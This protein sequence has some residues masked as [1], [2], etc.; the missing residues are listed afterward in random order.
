[1]VAELEFG[2]LGPLAVRRHGRAVPIAQG[3]QRAVLAALLLSAG[4]AV[5]TDELSEALWGAEPPLTAR[6]TLQNYVMRLRKALGDAG[7]SR[8]TAEPDGY[9]IAVQPGEL[10][11]DRFAVSLA[12]AREAARAA[13]WADAAAGLAAGLSLWRGPPL[14]DI[15][16]P[17]LALRE[18]P[19][20]AELRLQALESRIDADL[21]LGRH[22]EVI[23]ELRQL[24]AAH[25]LRE[26][27][28]ELLMTALYRAGQRAEA[29]AAYRDARAVLI[30]ELGADPG[31]ELRRLQQRILDADPALDGAA[32]P[33]VAASAPPRAGPV[34][35]QL[36]AAVPN[37]AGRQGEL[38]ELTRFSGL[39]RGA[40]AVVISAIGG[41]AGVGKTALAVHWAHQAAG[42]FPDGQLYV[43]L[44]GY[45]S[46]R[47]MTAAEALAGFLRALGMAPADIPPG[48]EQRTASYRSLLTGQRIL[49]VLD[50]ASEAA[51]VRPLLP[52]SAGCM[53]VVTSR[54]SLA[55]L[56]ARD[57]ALRLELDVLAP[58]EAAALLR[59][60]IGERAA[61]D[62]DAA[63]EL[64]A[65]CARLPLALRLAAELAVSRPGL[66][67]SA[68]VR[69]LADQHRR[70]DLL[71]ADGDP[72]TAVRAVFS[73]SYRSLGA[74]EARLFRLLGLA[75]G[76]DIDAAAA[77]ALA[78]GAPGLG[79]AGLDR[80]ARAHFAG[81]T[82]AG[83]YVLHDLL[84]AYAGELA[85]EHDSAA[86]RQAAL[87]RL[88]DYYL[89][90][91]G[92]AMDRLFPAERHR[93]PPVPPPGRSVPPVSSG[94]AA[95]A[96][97][98]AERPALVAMVACAAAGGWPGHATRLAAT[99][100]RYLDAGGH[101]AEAMVVHGH[102]R[103][104]A[105]LDGDRAA[106]AAALTNLGIAGM[107][108][109][110]HAEAGR[111]LEQALELYRAAGDRPGEARVLQ[112]LSLVDIE[113][114]RY[115]LAAGRLAQALAAY[116]Q[117]G[118][119]TGQ[120]RALVNLAV[121]ALRTQQ[122]PAARTQLEE[123]RALFRATGDQ[124]GEAHALGNLGG[125]HLET[126]RYELAA[127]YL[128]QAIALCRATGYATGAAY[129]QADLGHAYL[130]QG[131]Y[132]EATQQ[133]EQALAHCRA[134]GEPAGEARALTGLGE[135]LGR[136][137]QPDEARRILATALRLAARAGDHLAEATAH[138]R[139][140]ESCHGAGAAAEAIAHWEAARARY[141]L[142]G[143]PRA[144]EL[145]ARLAI[146][147]AP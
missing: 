46:D 102:A 19:R 77:A 6:A 64:A 94:A 115:Q 83:R 13:R 11:T 125:V 3:K 112:N 126:G 53:A 14:A 142:L 120:A 109:G 50:N 8:I 104:A 16:S 57:G 25:P 27:L 60:L 1:M 9:R 66:P 89:H 28:H 63:R 70:L 36:P 75:P 127:E 40:G 131:R 29:L 26:R 87:T 32:G 78:G 118:D 108:Q 113:Q 61:A 48:T 119:R 39:P 73:W 59:A 7:R 44:R 71:D 95:Q 10:D 137:G 122:Y 45:A 92:T 91:A 17:A 62:P 33:A 52:G 99:L 74:A 49:V 42:Q 130:G 72:H 86:E 18:G 68:L 135:I 12:Q 81:I 144:A 140:A 34:P 84:R 143:S 79:R 139:L 90:G 31:H 146:A 105:R 147:S 110:L 134:S 5:T 47:P 80:L 138:E 69:E 116:R 98:D 136:T 93:R 129:C 106:E 51:Q 101:A 107:R 117:T 123:A 43:N 30:D 21:H 15:P 24:V 132:R 114:G 38:R 88:L 141:A 35:R 96:W 20:L 111:H 23:S 124:S 121:G 55:G 85:A 133:L 56:V 22:A 100:F 76:A 4:R 54:A 67:L 128:G 58:G 82:P 145:S 41:A 103:H 97:L 65:Q 37:F 2:L